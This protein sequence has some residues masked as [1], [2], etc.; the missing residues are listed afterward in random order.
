MNSPEVVLPEGTG[1]SPVQD[2]KLERLE[3]FRGLGDGVRVVVTDVNNKGA[4]GKVAFCLV[5]RKD[6]IRG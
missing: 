3:A 2:L 6:T 1:V 5:R 4:M